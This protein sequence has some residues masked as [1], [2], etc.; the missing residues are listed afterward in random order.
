MLQSTKFTKFTKNRSHLSLVLMSMS[1]TINLG[2]FTVNWFLSGV[3][4][5]I[6]WVQGWAIGKNSFCTYRHRRLRLP[7]SPGTW[8]TFLS[9]NVRFVNQVSHWVRFVWSPVHTPP[10]AWEDFS[11]QSFFKRFLPSSITSFAFCM[12]DYK[13]LSNIFLLVV[14]I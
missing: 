12:E 4:S 6:H 2:G 8:R 1:N 13:F 14:S 10:G 7:V 3:F 11:V 5:L 9:G